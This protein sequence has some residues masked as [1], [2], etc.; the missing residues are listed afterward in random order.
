VRFDRRVEEV[1]GAELVGVDWVRISR[2][3]ASESMAATERPE[4][5]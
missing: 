1:D 2:R 5:Q 4:R 3:G